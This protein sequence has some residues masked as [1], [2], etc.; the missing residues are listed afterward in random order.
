MNTAHN[1]GS[2]MKRYFLAVMVLSFLFTGASMMV[3]SSAFAEIPS[4]GGS[5]GADY[6][7]NDQGGVTIGKPSAPQSPAP[8]PSAP[9]PANPGVYYPPG[10][11]MDFYGAP[12]STRWPG[13]LCPPRN[14][15]KAALS[16]V[17]TFAQHFWPVKAGTRP[18]GSG[19][20]Y[21]YKVGSYSGTLEVFAKPQEISRRCLY[22]PR[23]Y[24]TTVQCSIAYYVEISRTVPNPRGFG[25]STGRTGYGEGSYNYNACVNSK[26][27]AS[28][29]SPVTEYGYYIVQAWQ[30]AANARVEIAYTP[31]EVTGAMPGPKI[32]SL[33][34]AFT[35]TKR[36][37]ATASLDCK[38]QF[39]T[40]GLS[41]ITDWTEAP[42][43]SGPGS[44]FTCS[45]QPVLF[46][47]ADG[48]GR[49]LQSFSG[50]SA[51]F[52]RD[53]KAREIVFNQT[54]SGSRIVVQTQKTRFL[55]GSASTPWSTSS[56]YN[57][58]LFEL[59]DSK[60]GESILSQESGTKSGIYNGNKKNV[61]TRGYAASDS[62]RP[63]TLTQKVDWTGLRTITSANITSVNPNT[64]QV[65]FTY[66]TRQVP[67]SGVCNQSATLDY[68]RSIG[69]VVKK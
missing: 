1:F 36:T 69:D 44:S 33:S 17:I 11:G 47:T 30:R 48:S 68:V 24:Y 13:G 46:D 8:A 45:P 49:S 43:S 62:G 67:T 37:L 23:V 40:P 2:I 53:G 60:T 34:P 56:L 39:R 52:T 21:Q 6:G 10:N 26:G 28:V 19:W 16:T 32:V 66:V 31:N 9:P 61:W 58:N 63:T 18:P 29:N 22:P 15:G 5:N 27:F 42:C 38:N 54:V 57:N 25:I 41:G 35:T 3:S 4:I 64:N 7:I 55:R 51:Q 59:S 14:D 20:V 65:G 12:Y 50:N